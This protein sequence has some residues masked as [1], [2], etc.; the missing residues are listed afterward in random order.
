MKNKFIGL[1][2]LCCVAEAKAAVTLPKI[3]TANMVLQRDK[4][5]KIWGWADKGETITVS[6]NGQSVRSKTDKLGN[7]IV[8]LKPM[9][10]GGPYEMKIAG[11][12]NAIDLG[13][14]LIGDVYICSGQS[15]M[16]WVIQNTNNAEKE[17]AESKYPQ[18]RLFT[19]QKT[20]SFVPQKDI[21]GGEWLECNPKTTGDFSAV[22][23]FFGRKLNKDLDIPIGLINSS[24]GGTNVQTWISWDKMSKEPGYEN[25]NFQQLEKDMAELKTKQQ[26]FRQSLANDKGM[27]EKW[28]DPA[29]ATTGWKKIQ[30]PQAWEATEIGNADGVIWF[31]KEF[32]VP[33]STEG[34]KMVLSLG[35]IDDDD[36]TYLNGKLIGSTHIWNADRIYTVEA[37][38]IKKGTNTIVIKVTD[39]GGGGGL[40]GKEEQLYLEADGS[41]ILLAGEWSYKTSAVTTEFGISDAGPNSFPSQLY[42]A[43][44]APV[45]QYAIKGGIWY[46]GESNAGEAYNYRTLFPEMI[47]DWRSKWGYEFPFFWVQLANFMKPDLTPVSSD[48][49]ELREAQTMTLSLPQT[50]QAVIIDIGEADDIH[51]RNKQDVGYRLALAAEKV[52]YEKDIVYSGPVFETMRKESN[53]IILNFTNT[54][55]GLIAKDKYGY[56]KGFT[57]GGADQKFIWAKA[58]IE[59]NKVIVSSETIPDPIAVRY[60]WADNPDD[61]NLYNKEGLPAS[62]FRTDIWKGITEK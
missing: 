38:L 37:G 21:E 54:G 56:L 31:K 42:N 12:K 6:F 32:E 18:I 24:W 26:R 25:V 10:Y 9:T 1:F 16:E 33:E 29:S 15:N 34:K 19:V 23:Y 58:W 30:L 52:A 51:P 39:T 55:G 14:I 8:T 44:I 13:N 7:W 28:Y 53:K 22:A 43:M 47:K 17:I 35:P 40:Y 45:I 4:E 50:G 41:K 27:A 57:I 3:F 2:L 46:Q 48:W 5:I 62:P 36:D 20:M 59:G 61:A 49:A 60:A 11:K